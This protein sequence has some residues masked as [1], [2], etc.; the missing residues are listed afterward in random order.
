MK[1]NNAKYLLVLFEHQTIID[2]F[3]FSNV[4]SE[5]LSK[6]KTLEAIGIKSPIVT[7]IFSHL[8]ESLTIQGL[9]IV[10]KDKTANK[11]E[12]FPVFVKH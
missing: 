8:P 6:R 10:G 5:L 1:I 12:I 11:T 9:T 3:G 4:H 2:S 7:N